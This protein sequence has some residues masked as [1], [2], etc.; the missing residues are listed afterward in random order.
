MKLVYLTNDGKARVET[1]K[2]GTRLI[3]MPDG[4]HPITNDSVWQD[5]AR[6]SDGMMIL[7]QGVL[8]AYGGT[9]A[10]HDTLNVLREVEYAEKSF[11]PMSNSKMWQRSLAGLWT[12]GMKY[13]ITL[14]IV[15]LAGYSIYTSFTGG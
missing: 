7:F 1:A 13:G 9:M 15:A 11:K 6:K 2:V 8:P 14:F 5:A 10:E 3:E 4:Y 12:F